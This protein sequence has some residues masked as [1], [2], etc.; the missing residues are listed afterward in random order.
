M[1]TASRS[2]QR[3]RTDPFVHWVALLLTTGVGLS[4]AS[5][6]WL[7]LVA[8][9][10]LV[11]L[12]APSLKRALLAGLAFGVT[13]LLVWLVVLATNGVLGKVLAT[14]QFFGIAVLIGV[15]APLLGSLVRGVV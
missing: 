1:S 11:G 6:H 4:L 5:I 2:L 3:V 10:A 15:L 13:A 14:G 12:V 9:G 7:G 8:G